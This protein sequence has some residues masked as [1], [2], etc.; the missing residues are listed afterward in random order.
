MAEIDPGGT[1][2]FRIEEKTA[3]ETGREERIRWEEIHES[4]LFL[5]AK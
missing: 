3:K 5:E 4:V 2:T 1:S